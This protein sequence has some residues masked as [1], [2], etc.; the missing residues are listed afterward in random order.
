MRIKCDKCA[1][2]LACKVLSGVVIQVGLRTVPS[3]GYDRTIDGQVT[4]TYGSP[5]Y[6]PS[7]P[8]SRTLTAMDG[9][10]DGRCMV[11]GVIP[12]VANDMFVVAGEG[13]LSCDV[14]CS[15]ARTRSATPGE[16][17]VPSSPTVGNM[18]GTTTKSPESDGVSAAADGACSCD[19]WSVS[20]RGFVRT[21]REG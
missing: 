9:Y 20:S 18:R 12:W 2:Y 17:G 4:G 1:C 3:G 10:G 21:G 6:R 13:S 19:V 7:S 14:R 15:N 11:D 5:V 16:G 8:I